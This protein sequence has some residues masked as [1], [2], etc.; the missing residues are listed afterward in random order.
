M[1]EVTVKNLKTTRTRR[2]S[3]KRKKNK[4]KK[5]KP[6]NHTSNLGY[7]SLAFFEQIWGAYEFRAV[8]SFFY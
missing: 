1:V 3:R 4:K 2:T 6:N 5:N 8:I 7:C